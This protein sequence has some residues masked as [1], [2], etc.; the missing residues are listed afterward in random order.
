MC[1]ITKDTAKI[2]KDLDAKIERILK[3]K[4]K[5]RAFKES[6][7]KCGDIFVRIRKSPQNS[8]DSKFFISNRTDSP[9]YLVENP[10]TSHKQ[11]KI[12]RK[13]LPLRKNLPARERRSKENFGNFQGFF[14]SS[15]RIY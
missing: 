7:R 2:F 1:E 14:V 15:N 6:D 3:K 12:R 10:L 8:P 13:S 11:F 9:Y 4:G 5:R